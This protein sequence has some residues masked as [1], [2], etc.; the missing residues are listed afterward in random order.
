M[1]PVGWKDTPSVFEEVL[2]AVEGDRL[3]RNARAVPV[4]RSSDSI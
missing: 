1:I 3:P 4:G 2:V